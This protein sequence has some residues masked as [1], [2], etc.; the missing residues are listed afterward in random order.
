MAKKS[1]LSF[2]FNNVKSIK[3]DKNYSQPNYI[4]GQWLKETRPDVFKYVTDSK[5]NVKSAFVG[6]FLEEGKKMLSIVNK[7]NKTFDNMIAIPK[8]DSILFFSKDKTNTD[9]K[10]DIYEFLNNTNIKFKEETY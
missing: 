2:L 6:L 4:F 7:F 9:N 8:Y 5:T 10:I 1:S 3:T